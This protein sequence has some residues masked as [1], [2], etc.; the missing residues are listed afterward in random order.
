MTSGGCV[1]R[2]RCWLHKIVSDPD[3]CATVQP[4]L[5]AVEEEHMAACHFAEQ[6]EAVAEVSL[7][8]VETPA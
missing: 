7:V 3:R 2:D 4:P 5:T 1:F 8:P 6:T